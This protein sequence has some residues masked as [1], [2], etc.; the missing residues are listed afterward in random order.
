[1]RAQ[2]SADD[3]RKLVER[4]LSVAQD[5]PDMT[6]AQL[7]ERFGLGVTTVRKNLKIAGIQ[8]TPGRQ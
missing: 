5:N 1:M 2:S 7:S 6:P 8:V 3:T 4:M